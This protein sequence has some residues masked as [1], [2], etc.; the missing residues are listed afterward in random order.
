MKD[1]LIVL[2]G[3]GGFVGRYVAQE[4]LA[5]GARVR[6]AQRRP[7]D[8]WFLKPLGN[9]GQTQFVAA[10]VTQPE[11]IAAAVAGADAV[12]NLVGV[13]KGNFD[14]VNAEGAR[15]VAAAAKAAGVESLVHFSALGAER[16]SASAYGRSKAAGEAAVR[17]TF[18]SA[19]ILRPSFIFGREDQFTNRFA[20]LVGSGPVVPVL[21]ADVRFQPV[22][23][24]DVAKAV[25]AALADPDAHG[26]KTYALAG[27]DT[28]TMAGLFQ[29]LAKA[30][31]H[32]P[33]FTELPDPIG[34]L[35]AA[36]P[37][38]PITRDQWRMLQADNVA[39]DAPGLAALGI[40][41]TPLASAAPAWLVRY[42]R[43]G[44]FGKL[45]A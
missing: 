41:P 32:K 29:W 21:R 40:T 38:T 31:G 25:V 13:L 45:A 15:T 8:A 9:L 30:T 35:I 23:V 12:V 34:A 42:R 2:I 37:G 27:P 11:T 3:G 14:G 19:T 7:R 39:G 28:L 17:G 16:E 10:D 33:A 4:L 36:L 44:R 43:H 20:A 18:P 5:A 24:V 6:I 1:K 26:G 22:Y